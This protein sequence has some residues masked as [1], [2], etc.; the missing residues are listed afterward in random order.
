MAAMNKPT[1]MAIKT[2]SPDKPVLLFVSFKA[3]TNLAALD[4][5]QFCVTLDE[6]GDG[7]KRFLENK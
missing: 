3:Q 1:F 4:L 2:H 6:N 7:S 5:I